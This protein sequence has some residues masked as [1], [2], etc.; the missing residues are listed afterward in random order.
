MPVF[1]CTGCVQHPILD[2]W[3]RGEAEKLESPVKGHWD[4][5]GGE[6]L[7]TLEN[8]VEGIETHLAWP[9]GDRETLQSQEATTVTGQTNWTWRQ[10]SSLWQQ[11]SPGAGPRQVVGPPCLEVFKTE[12]QGHTLDV[13]ETE[14]I[15]PLEAD[16][17]LL[18]L[19]SCFNWKNQ[20]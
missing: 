14:L 5:W 20:E 16:N 12:Q 15:A 6:T 18:F 3:W 10:G 17:H 11:R 7:L 4:G 9:M 2:P 19:V 13:P 8:E 1:Q